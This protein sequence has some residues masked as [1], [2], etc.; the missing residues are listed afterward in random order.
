MIKLLRVFLIGLFF[1]PY[2]AWAAN[3]A[4]PNSAPVPTQSFHQVDPTMTS[5]NRQVAAPSEAEAMMQ[6]R[7]IMKAAKERA[8]KDFPP[9]ISAKASNTDRN[10]SRPT[11]GSVF[12]RTSPARQALVQQS[13]PQQQRNSASSP[14][15]TANSNMIHTVATQ[16]AQLN[17]ANLMFQEEVDSRVEKLSF[18]DK[19]LESKL[20]KLNEE[21]ALL[22]QRLSQVA[23]V[24]NQSKIEAG[25][26]TGLIQMS[27]LDSNVTPSAMNGWL[28]YVIN[29]FK[30]DFKYLI[31][32]FLLLVILVLLLFPRGSKKP[33]KET[34]T[35]RPQT[36]TPAQPQP[37]V[38]ESETVSDTEDEYD[39]MGSKEAIPAQLDLAR[40]YLA[41]EDFLAAKRVLRCVMQK[42]TDEQQQEAGALLAQIN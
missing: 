12:T 17:Q 9:Q 21:M 20:N 30:S 39:F 23:L 4:L 19:R 10:A 3:D 38:S 31:I 6:V 36:P 5:S 34:T 13:T 18:T 37:I 15:Q 40:A 11:N 41:M 25:N 2:I 16:I 24:V 32:I 22:N 26:T 1:C 28:N 7:A 14:T 8:Q 27:S 29:D 42:G 33:T 35:V